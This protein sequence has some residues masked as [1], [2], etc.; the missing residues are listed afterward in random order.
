MAQPDT[1]RPT[2]AVIRKQARAN[3]IAIAP[4]REQFVLAGAQH[5]HEAARRLDDIAADEKPR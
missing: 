1:A 5:L 2:L 3:G 4:E